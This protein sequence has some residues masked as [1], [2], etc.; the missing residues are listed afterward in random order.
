M[1][2]YS[3]T[4]CFL[5]AKIAIADVRTICDHGFIQRLLAVY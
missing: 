2:R 3:S 1:T 4:F 5:K